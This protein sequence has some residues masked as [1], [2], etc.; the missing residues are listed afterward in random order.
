MKPWIKSLRDSSNVTIYLHATCLKLMTSPDGDRVEYLQAASLQ[1]NELI[2]RAQ[3]Y[4]LATGGLETPRILLL[5]NDV[6]E[7][8][9]G[10]GSDLVGR[11]YMSHLHGNIGGVR[12]TPEDRAVQLGFNRTPAHI[13]GQRGEAKRIYSA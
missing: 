6:H 10:N 4:V 2:V 11:F 9:L 13:D 8:G 12:I 5:S 7:K 3:Q 1:Q